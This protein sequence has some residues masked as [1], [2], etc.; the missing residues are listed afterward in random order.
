MFD[1]QKPYNDLP[2]LPPTTELESRSI[3][4]NAIKA[5]RVLASLNAKASSIPN[6]SMLVNTATLKEAKDSSE[7]ENIVTTSD[8]LFEG[9]VLDAGS[10]DPATKEVLS[11]R[12]ALWEG[13]H[14]VQ[15]GKFSQEVFVKVVQKIKKGAVGI[16]D[17]SGTRIANPVTQEVVYTPPEGEIQIKTLLENLVLYMNDDKD[18]IDPLVKLAVIH[19]QFEAIHPFKDG[20]GRTGRI[21]IILYLV[22]Q[23]LLDLPILYLSHYLVEHKNAY[24]KKLRAVTENQQWEQWILF[25]LEGITVTAQHTIAK[26]DAIQELMQETVLLARK[27]LPDRVYSKELIELLF[28]QPYTKGSFLVERGIAKRQTA[29]EYLKALEKVGIL[30]SKKV[31]RE[32]LYQNSWLL[33]LLKKH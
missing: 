9:F 24:Y 19:Y 21:I 13:F 25:M 26:I 28:E 27:K 29:A 22:A 1:P 18:D 14:A 32:N 4:K 6:Q 31:G 16:R 3:L 12:N 10:A 7:I 30:K 5:N 17:G 8:S 23:N 15:K 33:A 11:Y 2:L 20:N